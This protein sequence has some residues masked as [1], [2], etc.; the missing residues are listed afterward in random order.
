MRLKA[1]ITAALGVW[2]FTI[3]P[4]QG[5]S[6]GFKRIAEAA[7]F[8]QACRE[9]AATLGIAAST[10]ADA[11]FA[12]FARQLA[13]PHRADAPDALDDDCKVPAVLLI[14]LLRGNGLDAALVFVS[15]PRA[16]GAGRRESS[17]KSNRVLVYVRA[18]DRYFDPSAPPAKQAVLDAILRENTERTILYGPSLVVGPGACADLCMQVVPRSTA[19]TVRVK[20]ETIRR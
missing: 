5:S 11:L 17:G 1:S 9:R 14:N 4:G 8:S 13:A 15:M 3:V 20:T 16:D 19:H 10:D 18:R 7:Y 2:L 6:D 12:A